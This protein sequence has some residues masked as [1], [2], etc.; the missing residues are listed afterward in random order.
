ME[1]EIKEVLGEDIIIFNGAPNL[2][3][4]LKNVLLEQKILGELEGK[5]EFIDSQNSEE[6]KDRFYGILEQ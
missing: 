4:H 3:K 6:K 5:I 1:K 2:A